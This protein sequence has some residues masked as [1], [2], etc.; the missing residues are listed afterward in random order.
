MKLEINY[1]KKNRKITHG[2]Q[3]TWYQ[4]KKKQW[5]DEEIK[6]EIRKYAKTNENGNTTFQNLWHVSKAVLR[7]KFTVIQ[8]FL[9]I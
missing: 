8:A 1:R 2:D 6:G 9:K 7:G 5:F 3:T 4:K